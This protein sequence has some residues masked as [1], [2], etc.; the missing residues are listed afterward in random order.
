LLQVV[1]FQEGEPFLKSRMAPATDTLRQFLIRDGYFAATIKP[2][3]QIDSTNKLENPVFK[4]NLGRRAKI[5]SIEFAGLSEA[6]AEEQRKALRSLWAR[7]K[8]AVLKPGTTYTA[9]KIQNAID[10]LRSKLTK[11]NRLAP[12]IR[13]KLANFEPDTNRATVLFQVT[14]GPEVSVD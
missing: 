14:L 8:G 6:Q 7:L 13:L 9:R 3:V 11:G 10:F 4:V 2:E 5:G 12:D 1:Q